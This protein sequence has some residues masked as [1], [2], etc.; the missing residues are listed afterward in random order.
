MAALHNHLKSSNDLSPLATP[1]QFPQLP[2][3]TWMHIFS[4]LLLS[5]KKPI[6]RLSKYYNAVAIEQTRSAIDSHYKK[7]LNLFSETLGKN[8]SGLMSALEIS[9]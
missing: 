5:Q 4:F 2:R 9:Y 3:E 8:M 7:L 6:M 1:E